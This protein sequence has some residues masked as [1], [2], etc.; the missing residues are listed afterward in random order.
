MVLE[1]VAEVLDSGA[2]PARAV[3]VVA[4]CLER[5][6]DPA[7]TALFRLAAGVPGTSPPAGSEPS[8]AAGSLSA[9]LALA[10][11]TGAGPVRLIRAAAEEHRR[12]AQAEQARAA[13]RLGVLVLLPTGLCL[14][15]AFVLLTVIPLVIDL[16][17]G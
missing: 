7:A 5:G 6:G 1:L 17:L 10:V 3:A 4:E 12:R 14:L 13:R 2:S 8:G 11:A 16:V 15:P 9:A